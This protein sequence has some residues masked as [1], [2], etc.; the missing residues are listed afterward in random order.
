M[1]NTHLG[2]EV[3]ARTHGDAKMVPRPVQSREGW[4][5]PPQQPSCRD[6]A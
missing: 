1:G 6:A 5:S 3:L 4:C 2:A